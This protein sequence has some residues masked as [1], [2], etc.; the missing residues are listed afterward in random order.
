MVKTEDN[1]HLKENSEN[2]CR[3]CV[4]IN[5][6]VILLSCTSHFY[7]LHSANKKELH[8][9]DNFVHDVEPLRSNIC[10]LIPF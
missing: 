10:K 4:Q 6:H 5:M 7:A 9:I 8:C 1:V 2:F 3:I